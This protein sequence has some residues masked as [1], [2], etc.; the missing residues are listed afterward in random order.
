[1]PSSGNVRELESL[2][3][4]FISWYGEH[5]FRVD[6]GEVLESLT[7]FFRFYPEF[8]ETRTITALEPRE[9]AA[10]LAS[11]ITHA[12]LE[13]CMATYSLMRFLNFLHDSG[14]WSGSPESFRAVHGILEDILCSD[15]RITIRY[16][17][18]PDHVPTRTTE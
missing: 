9:V 2:A 13:G 6:L 4:A 3:P 18:M 7:C 16:R 11:L 10:K 15:L 12:V 8:N 14:R 5:V 17:P 1:M